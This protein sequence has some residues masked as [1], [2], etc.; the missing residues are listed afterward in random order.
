MNKLTLYPVQTCDELVQPEQWVALSLDSSAMAFFTDFLH[1]EPLV[2]SADVS[3]ATARETM[4]STHVRLKLVVDGEGHFVGVISAQD[5]SEQAIVRHIGERR[6]RRQDISVTE[7]MTRKKDL[8]ALDISE[9][10]GASIGDV[11]SFLKDNHEQ[12]CL[13]VDETQ[14]QIR[15]IFSASDISRRLRLPVNIQD[16]SSFYR[17]FAQV[18]RERPVMQA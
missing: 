17:V 4:L 12:H 7:L 15:G 10:E 14:H 1:N 18:E 11:V 2:I 16:Q 8:L 9:V 5:L 6:V 3:A 13:V